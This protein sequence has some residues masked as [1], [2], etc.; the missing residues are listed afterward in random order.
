MVARTFHRLV[1]VWELVN[2]KLPNGLRMRRLGGHGSCKKVG[3]SAVGEDPIALY[4]QR[5]STSIKVQQNFESFVRAVQ[6]IN[7]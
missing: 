1:K 5:L 2:W 3:L 4:P 6:S 7:G